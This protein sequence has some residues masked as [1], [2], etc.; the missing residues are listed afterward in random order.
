[1]SCVLRMS[2]QCSYMS[3]RKTNMYGN[4]AYTWGFMDDLMYEIPGRDNYGANI[5]DDAT[6]LTLYSVNTGADLVPVNTANFHR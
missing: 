6:G 1:M 4:R 5:T 2:G 3:V